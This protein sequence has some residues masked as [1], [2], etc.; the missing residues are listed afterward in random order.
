MDSPLARFLEKVDKDGPVPSHRQELGKCWIWTK[1]LTVYGYGQT[2]L[3]YANVVA[4]RL[5]YELHFGISPFVDVLHACD[6][7]KC[8]N[9]RHLWLGDA[10]DNAKDRNSKGRQARGLS[11]AGCAKVNVETVLTVRDRLASGEP[12]WV[13]ARSI[14]LSRSAVSNINTRKTWDFV[15]DRR[16][17]K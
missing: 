10:S 3:N 5:S 15:A 7:R 8:V 9:P 11:A 6:N 12:Q 13:I 4:H 2:G 17:S 16:V 1:S 14:G